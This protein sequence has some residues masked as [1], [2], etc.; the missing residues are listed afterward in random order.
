MLK[1][2]RAE[3]LSPRIER[4]LRCDSGDDSVDDDD[5]HTGGGTSSKRVLAAVTLVAALAFEPIPHFRKANA[6]RDRPG[7]LEFVRTWDDA[8]FQ[9]QI[10]MERVDFLP[11]VASIAPLISNDAAMG[12]RSSGSPVSPELKVLMTCRLLAGAQYLDLIWFQV[13]VNHIWD[14]IRPV[15]VA[16]HTQV[17]NVKLPFT[18]DEVDKHI[19]DWRGY[20]NGK[21][22]GLNVFPGVAGAVDG[23]VIERTRPSE[24]ELNGK[25]FRTYLNRAGV[26]AWVSMAIVG[27]YCQ[28]LMFEIKCPG[29]TNDCCA[30]EIGEG[31]V[32]LNFLLAPEDL[33]PFHILVFPASSRAVWNLPRFLFLA[34]WKS[35][36]R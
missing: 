25:D 27:A 4:R 8:M 26:F 22:E 15:L 18:G 6:H 9:R 14:Y 30:F 1:R 5:V 33:S 29:A 17:N 23:F 24:R 35:C 21:F 2:I 3:A 11:L 16:I 32:W 19:A 31:L 12:R 7:A 34:K 13:H 36:Y 10:R 20:M 28:F